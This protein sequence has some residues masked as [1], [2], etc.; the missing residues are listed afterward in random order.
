ML[1]GHGR[2]G[3]IR[4]WPEALSLSCPTARPVCAAVIA[5]GVGRRR[6]GPAARAFG[7][8]AIPTAL[9]AD[10]LTSMFGYRD[11]STSGSWERP[12]RNH[13]AVV[14]RDKRVVVGVVAFGRS[15]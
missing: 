15:G 14:G 1:T 5:C 4:A 8:V 3:F 11:G 10:P 12:S 6:L 9:P 7:P 13:A 2:C